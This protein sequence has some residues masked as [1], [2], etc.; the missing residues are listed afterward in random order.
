M[1]QM[2]TKIILQTNFFARNNT[3]FQITDSTIYYI[4]P[5]QHVQCNSFDTISLYVCVGVTLTFMWTARYTYFVLQWR[6]HI[7]NDLVIFL[8]ISG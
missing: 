8:L 2:Q 1:E 6:A 5:E 4:L 7:F 3:V